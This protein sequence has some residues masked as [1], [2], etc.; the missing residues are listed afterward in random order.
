MQVALGADGEIHHAVP[1]N[2]FE[3]VVEESHSGGYV[4]AAGAV[5]IHL[6]MDV[7]FP[8]SARLLHN[9]LTGKQQFCN[10]VPRESVPQD[11]GAAADVACKLRVGVSVADDDAAAD[12]EC[13]V[14]DILADH[15][16]ARLATGGAVFGEVVVDELVVKHDTLSL[17]CLEDEVVYGPKSL[18][19][20]GRCSK[21]VLVCDHDKSEVEPF[22]DEP[23]IL[24]NAVDEFQFAE[25]V[26]LFVFRFG[27][28]RA[29]TVYK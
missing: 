29:V 12:V 7:C 5:E 18:F 28:E 25:R 6:D 16:E 10:L 9:P 22:A 14:V 26:D 24:E 17:Q 21:S 23:E 4:A 3:H 8:C 13:R 1:A 20:K 27:D 2:L 15:A 19:R 11:V